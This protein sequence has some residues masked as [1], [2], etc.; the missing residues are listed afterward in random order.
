MMTPPSKGQEH[1][2][3]CRLVDVIKDAPI[4]LS[5]AEAGKVLKNRDFTFEKLEALS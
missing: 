1:N 4:A 3:F 5:D 2:T